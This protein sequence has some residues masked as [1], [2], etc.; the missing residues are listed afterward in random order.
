[1]LKRYLSSH[2]ISRTPIKSERNQ[3]SKNPLCDI[4]N[5]KTLNVAGIILTLKAE[6]LRA[7]PWSCIQINLSHGVFA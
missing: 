6:V 5:K 3:S 4:N 2:L 7:C 1:M